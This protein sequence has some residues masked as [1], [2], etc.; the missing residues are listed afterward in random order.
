MKVLCVAEK[1]SI[2]KSLAEILNSDGFQSRPGNDKYCRNFD[3]NYNL[4]SSGW[5]DMTITSVRGHLTELDFTQSYRPWSSH[6]PLL[7]LD[8]PVQVKISKDA[9]SIAQNLRNEARNTHTL[10]IWTDCDREGEHIGAEVIRECRKAN[11]RLV[12]KRARFSAII[13]SQ[14]HAACRNAGELDWR[15]AAAVEARQEL[16]LRVGA[17]LTRLQTLGIKRSLPELDSLISYGPCQFPTL[18]FVVDQYERVKSF[19]SE[20]F[21]YIT[22]ADKRRQVPGKALQTVEFKWRRGHLFDEDTVTV[23]YK[24]CGESNAAIVRKVET[25]PV[26]KFKPYP[27]TTVELQ[28]SGSRLLRMTPKIILDVAEKLYN[29]G[30]LS[31][32]RTETDQYD[33]DFNF[34]LLLQKQAADVNWGTFAR[35]LNDGG[36]ERPRDGKKN[37]K[38]HP[39]IHPTAHVSNL[40]GDEAKV[41]EYV[42]RRFLACCSRDATGKQTHV[43]IEYGDEI[44]AASGLM[45]LE[46]NYLDVFPYDKWA[47]NILPSYS[48]GESFKPH[49]CNMKV[50]S[51]TPPNYLTEAD[52]VNLM[53]KNGIGTD[54]TIAEHIAKVIDRGYVLACKSGKTT[55]LLPSELGQGLV[56]GYNVIDFE[57]SLSKPLLRRET[58]YRMNL[59]CEGRRTKEE[60]I[61]ESIAEYRAVYLQARDQMRALTQSV[62][63]RLRDGQRYAPSGPSVRPSANSRTRKSGLATVTVSLPDDDDGSDGNGP[64]RSSAAGASFSRECDGRSAISRSWLQTEDQ[65]PERRPPLLDVNL[66][67]PTTP[68]CRC[69]EDAVAR[70]VIKDGPNKGRQFWSCAK[71]QSDG[72]CGYFDWIVDGTTG[73]PAMAGV[74]NPQHL[75]SR[76][77]AQEVRGEASRLRRSTAAAP[78][79]ALPP[80]ER[81]P[82][83]I[84]G[85]GREQNGSAAIIDELLNNTSSRDT[86][87]GN[88][89]LTDDDAEKARIEAYRAWFASLAHDDDALSSGIVCRDNNRSGRRSNARLSSKQ[90]CDCKLEA[91]L[92]TVS[93]E[94]PNKGRQFYCCPKEN[95][96]VRCKTFVWL[97]ESFEGDS[98]PRE[99]SSSG[100]WSTA[101]LSAR[102]AAPLRGN[103]ATPSVTGAAISTGSCFK[104]GG[105]GH[106][107]RDCANPAGLLSNSVG[108]APLNGGSSSRNASNDVCFKCGEGGHWASEC[109]FD[110]Q[111]LEEGAGARLSTGSFR[112]R[113]SRQT[114]NGASADSSRSHSVVFTAKRKRGT[115]SAT[116]SSAKISRS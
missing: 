54:A 70:T 1:P 81:L 76:G 12:V 43:E 47:G 80:R 5:V 15:A 17:A 21:W 46:R 72:S 40:S 95:A 36:L 96:S 66:N 52:L 99:D 32:P 106:W 109:P 68:R 60:T 8:A 103:R 26:R 102:N 73:S 22:V 78:S 86:Q 4:G 114:G 105:D 2:A 27:L 93:K 48:Q 64:G 113:S 44:F 42:T 97:N 45:I 14:I 100:Q 33:R 55:Y 94:G 28:K 67:G 25:K 115:I 9:E 87:S 30:F 89:E 75:F 3:L 65:N 37:D 10:I 6:D 91:V 85:I 71:G 57:K 92:R 23:L 41:Y 90:R 111:Q 49:A 11:A 39:P 13:A 83:S 38:A 51:T 116:T 69:S 59:I 82:E 61:Q 110:G 62:A 101:N 98:V 20:N 50:G 18:G 58:E 77:L 88:H 108:S 29:R 34:Q 7:L 56:E 31:Y 24:N 112:T 107:S 16:D 84:A 53:D 35:A 79:A 104:C 19:V 74:S 63:H